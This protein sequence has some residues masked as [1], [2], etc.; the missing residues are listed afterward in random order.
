MRDGCAGLVATPQFLFG[1]PDAVSVDGTRAQMTEVP[2]DIQITPTLRVQLAD[3]GHLVA[4]LRY[5]R[6]QVGPWMFGPQLSRH[7]HLFGGARRGEPRRHRI[8]RA[9]AA[10]PSGNQRA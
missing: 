9:S 6:L 1:E 2:V 3:P 8:Q 4:I 10:V 7:L 5:M